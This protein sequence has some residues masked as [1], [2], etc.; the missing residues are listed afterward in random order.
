M[1]WQWRDLKQFSSLID[2]ANHDYRK[3]LIRQLTDFRMVEKNV[4]TFPTSQHLPSRQDELA[5]LIRRD[6]SR[7]YTYF[8][9][10]LYHE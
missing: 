6:V 5:G 2:L 10:F 8:K 9:N 7:L 1:A 3:I 4:H